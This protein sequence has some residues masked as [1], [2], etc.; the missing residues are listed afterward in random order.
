MSTSVRAKWLRRI[1]FFILII[2]IGVNIR[3]FFVFDDLIEGNIELIAKNH[4]LHNKIQNHLEK[5]ELEKAK[6]ILKIEIQNEGYLLALTA[7]S[8]NSE[9]LRKII[10]KP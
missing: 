3:C 9:K 6:E 2:S 5:N 10:E 8:K 1:L 7:N 4:K